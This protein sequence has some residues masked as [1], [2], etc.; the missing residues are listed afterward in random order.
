MLAMAVGKSL[1]TLMILF[2]F[3]Q[4]GS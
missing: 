1:L 3:C 2:C 4:K